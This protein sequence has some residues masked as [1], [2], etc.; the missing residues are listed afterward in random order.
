MLSFALAAFLGIVPQIAAAPPSRAIEITGRVLDPQ[1]KPAARVR[2]DL[3]VQPSAAESRKLQ[4]AGRSAPDP[5]TG[6][7]TEADGRFRLSAPDAGMYKV[8]V[9]GAGTVPAEATLSPLLGDVELP[10]LRLTKSE[11]VWVRVLDADNQ[12]RRNARIAVIPDAATQRRAAAAG[13]MAAPRLGVPDETGAFLVTRGRGE[14]MDVTVVGADIAEQ[15]ASR[16]TAAT[17]VRPTAACPRQLVVR[18]ANGEPVASAWVSTELWTL[19]T[20]AADGTFTVAAPCRGE[21]RLLV[22]TDDGRSASTRLQPPAGDAP[23]SPVELKLDPPARYAGRVIDGE[24]RQ[25]LANALVW[26]SDEPAAFVHTDAKGNYA[27]VRPARANGSPELRAAARGHLPARE[28]L[29]GQTPPTFALQPTATLAG[30]VVDGSGQ[31]VA[32]AQV[33]VSESVDGTTFRFGRRPEGLASTTM[34]KANGAFRIDVL[35]RR[36]YTL[37]ASRAGFAPGTIAATDKLLP[38]GTQTGL[39]IVLVSGE[40][41]AGKVLEEG[42]SQPVA[43]AEVRLVAVTARGNLPRYM[44]GE[45]EEPEQEFQVFTD[46]EGNVRF[47]HLPA[48]RFD[49]LV[50]A[51]GF[52]PRTVRGLTIENGERAN[53]LGTVLLQRGAT[54]EGIVVDDD[55]QP[56]AGVVVGIYP[57]S[58]TGIRGEAVDRMA[59][60]D[61]REAVSGADGRFTISELTTGET[62]DVTARRSGYVPATMPKV[63]VPRAEPLQIELEVAARLSGRVL[64]EQGDPVAGATVTAKPADAALPA[65]LSGMTTETDLA[66]AYVLSDLAAG[67]VALTAMAKGYI[68]VDPLLMDVSQGRS[69]DHVDL[70]LRRG[71]AIEGT[72]LTPSGVPAIG[73]RV[74]LRRTITPDRMLEIEIAGSSRTDGDGRYRLEGVPVGQQMVRADHEAYVAVDRALQVQAGDNH[75]DL[76]LNEGFAVA[77]RV[78]DN[79]GRPVG[80][81]AVALQT[82]GPGSARQDVSGSDGAFRFAGV[83]AGRYNLSAQ[84]QGFSSASQEV[85]LA[86]RSADNLELRLEQGGGV[87]TGRVLGLHPQELS[88]LRVSAMK[89]PLD[90]M[91]GM[92]EGRMDSQGGS[93][94]VEGVHPGDWA[95]T[96]RLPDGRQA[97]K[98]AKVTDVSTPS[99]VDLDFG[100]GVALRGTVRRLRRPVPS[101]SVQATGVG[102]DSSGTAVTDSSGTF[103]ITGLKPGEHKV[104]VLVAQS[105]LRHEQVVHL[106]GDQS[107]DV[108]LPTARAMGQ[109]VDA[110]TGVPLAGASV[111]AQLAG[112]TGSL[113][114]R[115]TTD[116][117]GWF[118]LTNLSRGTYRFI[119]E[120]DGYQRGEL[121]VELPSDDA[122]L[123]DLRLTMEPRQ[124]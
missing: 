113:P 11:P 116:A 105:G 67:K 36:A 46:G 14:T 97:R 99:Q 28:K 110:A 118:E 4:L 25:P 23:A 88:Q 94:R 69:V 56:L 79:G 47:E 102:V 40:S 114:P 108:E 89:Q 84:K 123:Q 9:R 95:V 96:A 75:L 74:T 111:T 37:R 26:S 120:K 73:A 50:K 7:L 3:T 22:E 72:V 122:S 90:S 30:V 43:G 41:A 71:A 20:T 19:G 62:V 38:S 100:E 5:L 82:A 57:P 121:P 8:T 65:G 93:Y 33:N 98:T 52:A 60:P 92:K 1:G 64:T 39:R 124:R 85:Q 80:G 112:A 117:N 18:D 10:P 83:A 15:R 24:S 66:G 32:G 58:P 81:A 103:R 42:T 61:V 70:T 13:W 31:P 17:D 29:L 53:D 91:D 34:T 68:S 21:L 109:V 77:G 104:V 12:P 63:E 55:R 115:A 44:R 35:P 27:L 107:I 59:Q 51:A 54:L 6:T 106:A 101:A 78:V 2:V 16:V 45:D 86:D 49:L 48:G 87:I 119:A 76:R